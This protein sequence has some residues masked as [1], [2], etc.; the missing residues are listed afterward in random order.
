MERIHPELQELQ[1]RREMLDGQTD[2]WSETIIAPNNFIVTNVY[3]YN[4][5]SKEQMS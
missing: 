2:R 4:L 5:I 1:S 3:N